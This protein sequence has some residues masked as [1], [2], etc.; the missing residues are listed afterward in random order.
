MG[1]KGNKRHI[2]FKPILPIISALGIIILILA[3][4]LVVRSNIFTI[5][6]VDVYVEKIA[7]TDPNQVKD[8]AHLL[9]QNFLTLNSAKVES[10]LKKKFLCIRSIILSRDF[11]SRVKLAV[12]GREPVAILV[13][14]D[15]QEASQSGVLERFSEIQATASAQAFPA[16]EW[17]EEKGN[18][19]LID[20]EGVI[21]SDNIEQIN[22]SEE[23]PRIYI[24]GL[25]LTLGKLAESLIQ[26]TL[27]ILEKV[28]AFGVDIKE[29]KIYSKNILL[30]NAMPKMI[31]KLD[32]KIDIQIASLQL[33]LKVAKINHWTVPLEFI[34]LR[35]DKP[36]LRFA[37][38]KNG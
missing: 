34:D 10:D 8:S 4:F 24:S 38:K 22:L 1:R 12:F 28:K 2:I 14:I 9:G 19:F 30:I 5:T 27:K 3:S 15:S 32:D 13:A 25:N 21:Y 36:I 23:R 6:S 20:A 11:P 35:F 29:A 26:N 18:R 7:C 33:I 17:G 16:V 37:P 31:F